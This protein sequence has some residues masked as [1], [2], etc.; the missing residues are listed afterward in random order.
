MKSLDLKRFQKIYHVWTDHIVSFNFKKVPNSLKKDVENL[1]DV[2]SFP[3]IRADLDTERTLV[4]NEAHPAWETLINFLCGLDFLPDV[5][6]RDLYDLLLQKCG[7]ITIENYEDADPE[8]L[9]RN[10]VLIFIPELLW[11]RGD[12]LIRT[13]IFF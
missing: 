13:R 4:I 1:E 9:E 11:C 5:V 6:L 10:I 2:L 3:I 8:K 12:N 7:N